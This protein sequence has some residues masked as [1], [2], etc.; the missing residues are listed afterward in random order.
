MFADVAM[1]AETYPGFQSSIWLS[2][3]APKG[4]PAEV[5]QRLRVEIAKA[6]QKQSLKDR[7]SNAGGMEPL[8]SSPDQFANQIK[9]DHARFGKLV[10][11]ISLTLD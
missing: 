7:L 1:I 4:T 5:L 9:A 3:F 6:Q 8:V 11:Q 10:K 2:V